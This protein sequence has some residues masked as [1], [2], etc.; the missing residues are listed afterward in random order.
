[1]TSDRSL[2]P[3]LI[4]AQVAR[5]PEAIALVRD[6]LALSYG[7]LDRRAEH[8]ARHMRRLGVGPEVRVAVF[9]DRSADLVIALLACWKAGGAYLPLDPAYPP[10]RLTFMLADADAMAVLTS[11]AR[12]GTLPETAADVVIV[13]HLL[14]S[15]PG[16]A[17]ADEPDG[18]PDPEDLHP[19][20]R[21]LSHLIY[22]SG[23]T[24]R[25]K[26]VAIEHRST[27]AMAHWALETFATDRLQGVAAVTSICFDLSVYELF[28][29]LAAGGRVVL[30]D[31]ALAL[32]DLQGNPGLTLVNTV[33][34]AMTEL[35]RLGAIPSTVRTV[36]LA[37]EPLKPPLVREIVR[38][39]AVREVY[40]LY[41][42]SEDTTYSTAMR[43][44]RE[45]GTTCPIGR[46]I[47][48]TRGYLVDERMQ[49]V[50]EAQTGELL[51]AG[52]G[53]ARGYAN[54]PAQTAERFVPDPFTQRAGQRLY[55]T[56]DRVRQRDGALEFLNRTDHQVKIHG[57][58]IEPGEIEAALLDHPAVA[59][60]VVVVRQD[61]VRQD[62]VVQQDFGDTGRTVDP[63]L[64]AWVQ[65]T[66]A[67]ESTGLAAELRTFLGSSLPDYM[68]P[69][70]F[71]TLDTWPLT[72]NGKVD[73]SALAHRTVATTP[74]G[75]PASR[76]R[77]EVPRT[78]LEEILAALWSEVLDV[79]GIGLHDRVYELGGHS[80]NATQ[81]VSRVRN[82]L[83][84]ELT[85]P[86]VLSSPT[87]ADLARTIEDVRRR[88][89]G[90][91]AAPEI[92]PRG[93]AD[94]APP[95]SFA[96]SRLW[97][98]DRWLPGNIAYNL[99]LEVR[100]QG[101]LSPAALQAALEAIRRRHEALRTT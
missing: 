61:G 87:V 63:S 69:A 92:T 46:P 54:R 19:A 84:L 91:P 81:V 37:G 45:V 88:G 7:A 43:L 4:A 3:E 5:Q 20:P 86:Q 35:L 99:P 90:Q 23:S 27:A 83:Q 33:P 47:R 64:V 25:P 13:D 76:D 98:L 50:P 97:F 85:I 39:T 70:A 77:D 55:R 59:D 10:E 14:L 31:H 79:P 95:A 26:G 80:L 71:A 8:L 100:F 34:S 28:V 101:A 11:S 9:L 24:G 2:V 93:E 1:M 42:P 53:L 57:Y 36:N 67:A 30:F 96:Q 58:R 29:P 40:N 17:A 74:T 66:D 56:G 68:V 21:H 51:L 78:P 52:A 22:T 49:R 12:V 65:P 94:E 44:P 38:R 48:G 72:P 15:A 75:E 73:R 32:A 6:D 16:S 82:A 60:A 89:D 18:G 62:C 41:G